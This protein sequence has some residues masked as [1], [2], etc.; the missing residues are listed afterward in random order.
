[1]GAAL[2]PEIS[3]TCCEP[4]DPLLLLEVSMVVSTENEGGGPIRSCTLS[5][6]LA[7]WAPPVRRVGQVRHCLRYQWTTS[8]RI[9]SPGG[10]NIAICSWEEPEI[11]TICEII[12]VFLCPWFH[13][14]QRLWPE[15]PSLMSYSCQKGITCLENIGQTQTMGHSTKQ[16][17]S[18]FQKYRDEKRQ[19]KNRVTIAD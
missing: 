15:D 9:P 13:V 2:G 18:A 12:Q 14:F 5:A 7:R 6:D 17:A 10:Q 1:M 11:E 3:W 19:K 16:P 4:L 8:S